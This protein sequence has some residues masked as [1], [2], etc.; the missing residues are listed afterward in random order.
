[1]SQKPIRI[2]IVGCGSV[3]RGP[4]TRQIKL[5]QNK[6]IAVEVTRA[7]DV[8]PEAQQIVRE[9]FGDIPFSADYRA[10]V[11]SDDVDLVLVLTAMPAHGPVA[12]AALQAGKHAPVEKPM[13]VDLE[14]AAELVEAGQ[15][16]PRLP[17]ACAAC[18]PQPN[19]SGDLEA[20]PSWRYRPGAPSPRALRLERPIVGPVVLP[21]RAA[22]H[23]SI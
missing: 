13:A 9:R 12:R 21:S 14:T 10:V 3:M 19:L 2:G 5:I 18:R 22:A 15:A 17:A 23:C 7:C 11:E 6:G 4:Y 8:A 1:M 16:Q 20:H